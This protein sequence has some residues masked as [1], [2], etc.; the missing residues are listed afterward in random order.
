MGRIAIGIGTFFSQK[1]VSPATPPP[2]FLSFRSSKMFILTT[3][4]IAVFS[5]IFLYGII[6]PVVP[7]A[8]HERARVPESQSQSYVSILLSVYG[9]ALLVSSPIC[10]WFADRSS[11]RRM[12]LLIGLVA[13]GSS[14]VMLCLA[15]HVEVMIIGRVLQGFS[16]GIVWTTGIALLVD[17]VGEKDI[18]QVLGW[19]SLS[20]SV[21]IL[22]APLVGG[23]LYEKSGYY[24]VFYVAFA[25]VAVDIVLRLVLVEKKI[26]RQWLEENSDVGRSQSGTPPGNSVVEHSP[27]EGL[28]EKST[29][30]NIKDGTYTTTALSDIKAP[31]P[32]TLAKAARRS[33]YPPV[34]TL[35]KSRRLLAA[36]WGCIVQGSLLTAFDSVIPLYVQEIF[37]WNAIGAGLVF[38]AVIVPS[39]VAPVAGWLSDRHGP[40]YIVVTGFLLAIPLWIALRYVTYNSM[41]QK[42]LLCALLAMIGFCLAILMPPLS[43]EI[44]Y[45]VAAKE[46]K[47]PGLYGPN[48]AYAQAYGLFI[49][50]FAAGTMIGPVWAGYVR[51]VA[52]W[53]TMSW[54]LG[55]LSFAAAVPCL[56]FTGGLYTKTNGK[57]WR[58]RNNPETPS[59]SAAA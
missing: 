16:G 17:T 42:V 46:K 27:I 41:G 57:I 19:V 52:G 9:A 59:P 14:T 8:L 18:G 49:A 34:L 35:L 1:R 48:G 3:I 44:T 39:F 47:H 23:L 40:R 21:G 20:M 54:S 24:A 36:L 7:F 15:R 50:A 11:S 28:E 38:L 31:R 58:E 33:K 12:P 56:I 10:G 43:A 55:I 53:G 32:S 2:Y 4:C 45:V 25:L 30:E 37:G 29:E 26:A 5:D 6:V 22:L 13:L 51:G